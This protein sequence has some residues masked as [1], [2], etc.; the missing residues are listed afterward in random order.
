ME[1]RPFRSQSQ[2]DIRETHEHSEVRFPACQVP[3]L[4]LGS[5][6]RFAVLISVVVFLAGWGDEQPASDGSS[7]LGRH[8]GRVAAAASSPGG[9]WLASAGCESPILI[10]D[11]TRRQ[12]DTILEHCP[13]STRNLVFSP[14]ASAWP[15]PIPMAR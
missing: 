4:S 5:I 12:I 9:R 13:S 10:W 14:T 11:M 7:L 15:Q 8:P 1:H 6:L 3:F 2:D